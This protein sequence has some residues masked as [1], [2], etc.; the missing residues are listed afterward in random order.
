M[1]FNHGAPDFRHRHAGDLGN[2]KAD[3]NGRSVFTLSD[4]FLS[5][6]GARNIIGRSIVIDWAED[7][8]LLELPGQAGNPAACGVVGRV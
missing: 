3:A 2:I 6:V 5:L 1:Q 4:K 7:E 8:G